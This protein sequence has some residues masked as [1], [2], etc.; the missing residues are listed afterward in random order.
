MIKSIIGYLV[1]KSILSGTTMLVE[2]TERLQKWGKILRDTEGVFENDL[3]LP[4]PPAGVKVE[5]DKI[6]RGCLTK[7]GEHNI[8][9]NKAP[10]IF[11]M[12]RWQ[13]RTIGFREVKPESVVELMMGHTPNKSNHSSGNQQF[14]EWVYNH[15][16]K[17]H[18]VGT[19]CNWG[20][21][22]YQWWRVHRKGLFEWFPLSQEEEWRVQ[23]GKINYLKDELPHSIV[24]KI[25]RVK[26]LNLFNCFDIIAPMRYWKGSAKVERTIYQLVPPVLIGT[27]WEMPPGEFGSSNRWGKTGKMCH[28]F[29]GEWDEQ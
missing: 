26:R 25:L 28:F 29:L 12:R 6:A 7:F 21:V 23:I 4:D 19:K 10:N 1:R 27:I 11:A 5:F 24:L 3:V 22:P 9:K 17:E 20:A 2:A 14:Y 8:L 13:A 15:H 16:T 18:L